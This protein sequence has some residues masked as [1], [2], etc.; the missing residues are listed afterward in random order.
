MADFQE[1]STSERLS[2]I[3]AESSQRM[4]AYSQETDKVIGEAIE[5]GLR[6]AV[7][8]I[9]DSFDIE[10]EKLKSKVEL[11]SNRRRDL[12][13]GAARRDKPY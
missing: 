7:R 13:T 3:I 11:T 1:K 12:Q 10:I 4:L 6:S 8:K 9:N 5:R 2:S